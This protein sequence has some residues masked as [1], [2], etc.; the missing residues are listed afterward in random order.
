M[1]K[2]VVFLLT[3]FIAHNALGMQQLNSQKLFN[4]LPGGKK[5]QY[6]M[7]I[8][9]TMFILWRSMPWLAQI[10]SKDPITNKFGFNPLGDQEI[11]DS[12]VGKTPILCAQGWPE[13]PNASKRVWSQLD[14]ESLALRHENVFTVDCNPQDS[15]NLHSKTIS[16]LLLGLRT[17]NFG[18]YSDAQAILYALNECHKAGHTKVYGFGHS[19]GGSSWINALNALQNPESHTALWKKLR[20]VDTQGSLDL[21]KIGELKKMVE[22][23]HVFLGNPWIH[24]DYPFENITNGVVD[25]TT[26][27]LLSWL[28]PMASSF[29]T[30]LIKSFL[31]LTTNYNPLRYQPHQILKKITQENPNFNISIDFA[32]H[33]GVVGNIHN[34]DIVDFS[35]HQKN[36]TVRQND[37]V[38]NYHHMDLTAS[39]YYARKMIQEKK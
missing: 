6:L 15:I 25:T 34:Q 18:D 14:N 20:I 17:I 24:T 21:K 9:T 19:R 39:F 8:A 36:L 3:I 22:N 30:F 13:Q 7:C 11:L 12:T 31:A 4:A 28:K 38:K 37:D 29:G 16:G 2:K 26:P 27:N 32:C 23:G 10:S 35:K 33:D 1:K 5:T